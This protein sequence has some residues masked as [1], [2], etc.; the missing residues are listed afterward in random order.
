M[1][2]SSR[3]AGGRHDEV[4]ASAGE[5]DIEVEDELVRAARDGDE[6]AFRSLVEPR[7]AELKAHCYRMLGSAQDAE[8]ALQETLMRA[9]QGLKGF[10]GRSSVRV[11]LYRIATNTCLNAL[12]RRARRALPVALGPPAGP[13]EPI[14]EPV[15]EAVW[16]EPL[17]GPVGL[18]DIRAGPEARYE[19]LESVELA[20]VAALQHLPPNER[21]VL[22]LREVL[23]FSA[24][25]VATLLQTTPAAANSALQR[26][27]RI[28]DGRL[29][30]PSQQ[31][32]QRALGE[33]RVAAIV[34]RYMDAMSRA[35]VDAV[36]AL[37]AEDAT[38]SM[39]PYR[40]W[41]RGHRAIAA[42]LERDPFQSRWRHLA[43]RAN[44]QPAVA[45]YVWDDQRGA[46]VAAALDV[47]TMRGSQIAEIIGFL[48]AVNVERAGFPEL[49]P[50]DT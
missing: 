12:E 43:G 39:P 19:Q 25:D 13:H 21:A 49:F 45:G 10:E 47:L 33:E 24:R 32:V 8:D 36:V 1:P 48:G 16:I 9:W 7:M 29:P 34:T 20:F 2:A 31:E 26:A 22:V 18:D 17:P 46:F 41:Y 50:A 30:T 38:W 35:D 23:G 27:R 44:G 4:T 42:F 14:G 6:R 5:P 15:T 28:V 3:R 37:L 40:T 11:W